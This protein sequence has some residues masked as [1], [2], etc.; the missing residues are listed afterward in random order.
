MKRNGKLKNNKNAEG[1]NAVGLKHWLY[2][3]FNLLEIIFYVFPHTL[4]SLRD[5]LQNLLLPY[6]LQERTHYRTDTFVNVDFDYLN[7]PTNKRD[8]L[9]NLDM[10]E[11][12]YQAMTFPIHNL[13]MR[14]NISSFSAIAFYEPLLKTILLKMYK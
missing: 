11:P 14:K 4:L 10:N 8:A 7:K 6:L 1:E 2:R 5:E 13:C 3:F 9:D 12:S